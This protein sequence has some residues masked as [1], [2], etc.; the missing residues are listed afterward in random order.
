MYSLST[1]LI[2][3]GVS[4]TTTSLGVNDPKVGDKLVNGNE[5]YVFVY[6]AGADAQISPGFAATISGVSGYS[7]TVSSTSS[8]DLL[9]G[10]CKHATIATGGYGWLVTKGF[11]QVVMAATSGSVAA[12]G[13][14]ELSADGRMAPRS[15]TTGNG[16]YVGKAMAAIVSSAS[17]T[18]FIVAI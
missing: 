4:F 15:N 17:G 7:V 16:N 2:G 13:S 3:G 14:L 1:I 8:A 11:C 5:D 18:A 10:V 12:G 9:I 6:N